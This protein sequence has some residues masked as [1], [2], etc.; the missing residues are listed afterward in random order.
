[1][2]VNWIQSRS[3]HL[4]SGFFQHDQPKIADWQNYVATGNTPQS[5]SVIC[6]AWSS[7]GDQYPLVALVPYPQVFAGYTGPLMSVGS[8]LGNA[9]YK[10]LQVSVTRRAVKG[11]SVQASYNWS[12][13]HGD[14]DSNFSEPWWTGNLQNTYDLKNEAKNISDFD[15]TH[16]VKGYI[17][18]NLPFGRGKQLLSNV[19]ALADDI[20]GGWSL[21]GDFHYNTG[22]PI[23]VHSTNSIPGFNSIY[24]DLVPGCKLTQGSPKLNHQWLNPACFANPAANHLGTAGNYQEQ[25]RNPGMKTEDLA[26]HKTLSVGEDKRYNLTVR[27]EFFNVFNRDAL[28]G[29]DTGLNDT[30]STGK[31]MFGYINGYG[32]VGGRVGQFGA[33][34]T[35]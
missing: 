26:V 30:D 2:D 33:R 15:M 16:I 27:V 22:T 19:S 34:F 1:L 12:R 13:T 35:F 10:S 32:G 31:K 9:D 7:C 4:Q 24:I 21:D 8:P 25:V 6:A 29:P 28:A 14:V 3:Y 5:M 20:I 11:L 23:S 18:Y 17:I